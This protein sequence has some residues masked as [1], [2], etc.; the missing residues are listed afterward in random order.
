M[1]GA[2][3]RYDTSSKEV[4]QL[5]GIHEQVSGTDRGRRSL[6][7][8]NK[9]A[10]VL[11]CAIWEAYCEDL[12]DEALRH[13]LAH[14]PDYSKLPKLLQKGVAKELRND[15]NEL[16][17]WKLAGQGWKTYVLGRLSALKQRRDFDWNSPKAAGVE[18]F[19]ADVVGIP[20]ITDAWHWKHVSSH[21]AKEKLDRLVTLRGAIAHR[22]NAAA[23][24]KKYHVTRAL[25]LISRLVE[26]TDARVTQELERITGVAPW[27]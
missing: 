22:G 12:A 17:P 16:S 7:V 19:I 14:S 13:L 24:V 11:L 3:G 25:G 23:S 9:S 15:Q 26:E 8:L 27:T 2:A 21:T 6:E 4:E 18:K 10:I 1:S 5:L 20:N